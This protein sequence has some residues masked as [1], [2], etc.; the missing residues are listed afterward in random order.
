MRRKKRD[1]AAEIAEMEAKIKKAEGLVKDLK[2]KLK[3]IQKDRDM[4]VHQ[5]L[6][7]AMG[8]KNLNINDVLKLVK[9][10]PTIEKPEKKKRKK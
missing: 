4:E 2:G 7:G 5:A 10:A 1:F 3:E 9:D 6:A 8:E